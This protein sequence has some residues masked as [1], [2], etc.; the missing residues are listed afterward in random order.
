MVV[1]ER[2]QIR[3]RHLVSWY[4][5]PLIAVSFDIMMIAHYLGLEESKTMWEELV[6]K[7]DGL[8]IVKFWNPGGRRELWKW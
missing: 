2:A 3:G 8:S 1:I 5:V 4:D 7:V 6:E